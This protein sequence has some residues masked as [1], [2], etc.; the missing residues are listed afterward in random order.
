MSLMNTEK[1]EEE[2]HKD[3]FFLWIYLT[4]TMR[5]L[6]DIPAIIISRHYRNKIHYTNNTVLIEDT[7]R[8][9]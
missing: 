8:K 1:Y 3:I 9:L 2:Q 4:R 6:K 5:A 7:D